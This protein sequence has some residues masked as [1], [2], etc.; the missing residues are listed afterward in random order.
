MYELTHMRN[1]VRSLLQLRPKISKPA[2]PAPPRPATPRQRGSKRDLK[3]ARVPTKKGKG[4]P[5]QSRVVHYL[6]YQTGFCTNDQCH[7]AHVC[8]IVKH[9]AMDHN[10]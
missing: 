10:K 1:D 2:V 4:K 5:S 8:A 9:P 7:F 6:R 3:P